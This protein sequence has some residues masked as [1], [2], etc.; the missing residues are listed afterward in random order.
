MEGGSLR[1]YRIWVSHQKDP[2]MIKGLEFSAPLPDPATL[3]T[4]PPTPQLLGRGEKL[5]IEFDH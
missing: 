5:E 1:R 3:P 2:V 4:L